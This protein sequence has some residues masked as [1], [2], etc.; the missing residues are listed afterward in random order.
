MRI[1]VVIGFLA[2][3]FSVIQDNKILLV[4]VKSFN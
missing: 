3:P 1:F 2:K 4:E